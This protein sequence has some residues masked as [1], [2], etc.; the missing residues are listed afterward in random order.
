[1][2]P[3][4]YSLQITLY[5]LTLMGLTALQIVQDILFDIISTYFSPSRCV[6]ALFRRLLFLLCPLTTEKSCRRKS[7]TISTL[8]RTLLRTKKVSQCEEKKSGVT[9]QI[10]AATALQNLSGNQTLQCNSYNPFSFSHATNRKR[11]FSVPP[12]L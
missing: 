10:S 2:V 1:M 12:S 3:H 7:S 9:R 4:C 5:F 6:A 11:N 8:Q